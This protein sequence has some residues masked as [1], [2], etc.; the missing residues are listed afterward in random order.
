MKKL[1]ALA[2]AGMVASIG[3]AKADDNTGA[4]VSMVQAGANPVAARCAM[5]GYSMLSAETCE[6]A[7]KTPMNPPVNA[8]LEQ[9]VQ[10]LQM[11]M[12]SLQDQI[13][14]MRSTR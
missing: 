2:L 4:I 11:Q 13:N 1:V 6:N 7:A 12:N 14:A 9:Q 10:A 3:V 8:V 5:S